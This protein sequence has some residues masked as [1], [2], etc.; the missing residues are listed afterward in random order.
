MPWLS[1]LTERSFA[2]GAAP[3]ACSAATMLAT[4]SGPQAIRH[5]SSDASRWRRTGA[6]RRP[7]PSPPAPR[8]AG[9]SALAS[10]ASSVL[11]SRRPS[12]ATGAERAA[13]GDGAPTFASVLGCPVMARVRPTQRTSSQSTTMCLAVAG[14]APSS[15]ASWSASPT[16]ECRRECQG[17]ASDASSSAFTPPAST[18]ASCTSSHGAKRSSARHRAAASAVA[19]KLGEP[20]RDGTGAAAAVPG[21]AAAALARS[22]SLAANA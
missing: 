7:G 19:P 14:R 17:K 22:A 21:R 3:A 20:R 2:L 16:V 8:E 12:A 13:G 10:S 5:H 1:R 11:A 9:A 18:T 15:S 4:A 6:G